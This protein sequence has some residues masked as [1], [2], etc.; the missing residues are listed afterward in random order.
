MDAAP[1]MEARHKIRGIARADLV[2]DDADI[3]S[4]FAAVLAQINSALNGDRPAADS[5]YAGDRFEKRPDYSETV[6]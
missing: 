3:D 1:Y 2:E 4:G 6:A 5:Q